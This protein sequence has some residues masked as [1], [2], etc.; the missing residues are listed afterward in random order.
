MS[1]DLRASSPRPYDSLSTPGGE[2]R[3]SVS[4]YD[5]VASMLVALLIVVGSAV[6]VMLLIWLTNRI[7]PPHTAVPVTMEQLGEGDG[8]LIGGMELEAPP[9][10]EIAMETDLFEPVVEETLA[11]L[12]DAV[13]ANLATLD[14]PLLADELVAGI[15][16]GSPGEGRMVGEGTG[17]GTGRARRWEFRFPE[18]N[19]LASYARQLDHFQIELAVLY[20]ENRLVYVDNL[21]QPRPEVREGPADEEM[22]Y[23][24]TWQQGELEEADRALLARAGVDPGDRPILKLIPPELE[25]QLVAMEREHA[26]N[27]ADRIWGTRF[28]IRSEGRSFN[29]RV[30]EQILRD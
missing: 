24:L 2:N 23:Y 26:G 20:P 10:E 16:G 21:S 8:G 28:V 11:A 15:G 30:A 1:S 29:I 14:D 17:T 3:L 27:N 7:F 19:T 13:A 25:A 4:A 5:R 6:F 22:R 12:A 18:G 9:M